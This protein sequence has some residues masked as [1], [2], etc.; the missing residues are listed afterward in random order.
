MDGRVVAYAVE[1]PNGCH[2]VMSWTVPSGRSELLSGRARGQCGDDEPLGQ[3]VT[4]LAAG[5]RRVAWVRNITGNTESDDTLY[6]ATLGQR[7]RTLARAMRTGDRD[8][9]LAGKWIGGL[10]GDRADLFANRW[11]TDP[12]GVIV[13]GSL[14]AITPV[15][16]RPVALGPQTVL[17]A[18]LDSGRVA[19][20]RADGTVA[21]YSTAGR[22]LR[23][24]SPGS[25]R[26]VALDKASLEVLTK[27]RTLEVLNASTGSPVH[28]WAVPPGARH[29]DVYA[30]VA[31]FAVG[32]QLHALRLQT[33]LDVVIA[34]T[35]RVIVGAEIEAPGVV[36]AFNSLRGATSVGTLVFLPLSRILAA[37]S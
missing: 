10:A 34:T 7:Q 19:V 21:L 17:A 8:G 37:V 14:D 2:N 23:T 9:V 1:L 6:T 32:R 11:R 13:Q 36:Y 5:G 16:V 25:A 24:F 26:E 29:L 18:A 31:V 12:Q 20:L 15:R 27:A 3:D 28:T 4:A 33:G 35:R 22:A 30:G